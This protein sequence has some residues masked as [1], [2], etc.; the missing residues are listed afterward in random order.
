MT[1]SVI[2]WLMCKCFICIFKFYKIWYYYEYNIKY[3]NYI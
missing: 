1:I 3:F 2:L